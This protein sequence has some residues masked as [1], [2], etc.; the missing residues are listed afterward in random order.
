MISDA[1]LL[2]VSSLALVACGG[3]SANS[4]PHGGNPPGDTGSAVPDP[5]QSSFVAE[6][7]SL[8]ADGNDAATLTVTVR[9]AAGSP[10]PGVTV[11][12]T[13]PSQVVLVQPGSPTNADGVAVGYVTSTVSGARVVAA[14]VGSLTLGSVTFGSVTLTFTCPTWLADCGD[15]CADLLTDIGHCGACNT[16]CTLDGAVP[17]CA[18][19][20]CVI[21]H[22]QTG[23]VDWDGLPANGC[24][25][26]CTKSADIDTCNG[27]D[28]N[29]SGEVDEGFSTQ[30]D[31]RHCGA[32]C[33]PCGEGF[34]HARYACGAGGT[35][36]FAGCQ[37]GYWDINGEGSC[38]YGPCIFTSTS[39]V[40][41]GLDDNCDGQVD[42]GLTLPSPVVAC[43]VSPAA[44][45]PECISAVTVTC[46]GA[47]GWSCTFPAGVCTGA[48]CAATPE[49]C[50]GLDNNCNGYVDEN[51][52]PQLGQACASDDG[53]PSGADGACR[54]TGFWVCNGSNGL[55]CSAVK[56]SSHATQEIADGI[57]NDC[58]GVI[59]ET[60]NMAAAADGNF[61]KP[62][63]T[64]IGPSLW[65]YTYE[66]S[67]ASA[68]ATTPGSG[69]G[70]FTSAP[71]GK[72]LDHTLPT[73]VSDRL[74]W[75]S[76]TGPEVDQA[77]A[78]IGGRT[79]SPADWTTACKAKSGTCTWG[80][81]PAGAVCTTGYVAGTKFCNLATTYD[82][83]A[84]LAGIQ[85]GLLPT[86]STTLLSCDADW[87]GTTG[88]TAGVD[89]RI[90]DLTGN[91][92]EL[93]LVAANQYAL[94]GGSFMTDLEQGAT[95]SFT[96]YNV[97][98]DFAFRDA[99]FRC[100][101]NTDPRL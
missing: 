73:S 36:A 27:V 37:P 99:G 6:P 86:G 31:P 49:I 96:F 88:N 28:D 77:C 15:V 20:T 5:A 72:T 75:T 23:R 12:L 67:R 85:N 90:F 41:N 66:A 68:S 2:L 79:C 3:K 92:R 82:F 46:N 74:P 14:A 58:D 18:A 11:M 25:M 50:D 4:G 33:T 63:V 1:K 10:I 61:V 62:A 48:S 24:E 84:G 64:Q 42:E 57:D 69:N 100:C 87:S 19:G 52:G 59:D 13:A 34:P 17:W 21:D 65:I 53:K 60:Y 95:C 91:V 47:A 22:C 83:N 35:C 51:A 7:T 26:T 98:Q 78:A 44:T 9:D 94:M 32:A 81:D 29:C 70:Y 76:V 39:E 97:S 71:A 40:C 43:G 8:S 45:S 93:T 30:A 16:P 55:K 89:D 101:F 54:T 80:Y 38:S 56:D